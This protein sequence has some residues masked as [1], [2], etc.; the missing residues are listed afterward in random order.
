MPAKKSMRTQAR[1]ILRPAKALPSVTAEHVTMN[2]KAPM[3]GQV[4]N[5]NSFDAQFASLHAILTEQNKS[6][7]DRMDMQ[8]HDLAEIKVQTTKTNGRVTK[9][10]GGWIRA[11]GWVTGA[12]A[13]ATLGLSAIFHFFLK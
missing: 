1:K 8:D 3:A 11:V 13:V 7:N 2:A 10:E 9:L 5:P 4:F 6:R 12:A